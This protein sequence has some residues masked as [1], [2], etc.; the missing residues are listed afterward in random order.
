LGV[1]RRGGTYRSFGLLLGVE[2]PTTL[3]T[4]IMAMGAMPPP[5]RYEADPIFGSGP[6]GRR[7]RNIAMWKL[8][9]LIPLASYIKRLQPPHL[10]VSRRTKR[11][12]SVD[13]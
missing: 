3:T 10:A 6:G 12:P 8:L 13:T 4:K 7:A 5:L 11:F 1:E 2:A 9:P